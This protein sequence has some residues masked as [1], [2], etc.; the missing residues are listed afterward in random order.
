MK[1][2]RQELPKNED[3]SPRSEE[4]RGADPEIRFA[5]S[6]SRVNMAFRALIP[7]SKQDLKGPPPRP[8][9][10]SSHLIFARGGG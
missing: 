7:A 2:V 5:Q 1:C 6:W 3:E 8:A 10:S 9:R 4:D